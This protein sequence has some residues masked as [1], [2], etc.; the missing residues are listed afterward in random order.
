[1][2]V[3]NGQGE[4]V[5]FAAVPPRERPAQPAQPVTVRFF[6]IY[7]S[8]NQSLDALQLKVEKGTSAAVV[9]VAT[10]HRKSAGKR[11]LSA[12]LIDTGAMTKPYQTLE[13]DWRQK[14]SSFAINVRVDASGDLKTWSTINARAP[15]VRIDYNGERLEQRAIELAPRTSRYLRLSVEEARGRDADLDTQLELTSASL[16]GAQVAVNPARNWMEVNAQAGEQAGEYR[17]DLGGPYPVDRVRIGIIQDNT[18]ATMDVLVRATPAE[19]WRSI[20]HTVAY[21]LTRD[22]HQVMS[23][24]VSIGL[25]S[26]RYWLFR[27]DQRGGGLGSGQPVL[28]AGWMPQQIVFAAR[29]DGPFQIAYG[30]ARAQPAAYPIATLVPGWRDDSPTKLPQAQALPEHLLGGTTNLRRPYDRKVWALWGSLVLAVGVLAWM[31]WRLIKQMQ[32]AQS[33][34]NE[35]AASQ[36]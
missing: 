2:R 31:A 19:P 3:F 22:G 6:P 33:A 27:V 4:L 30:N 29:G 10:D 36:S 26:E 9:S 5:P 8:S 25:H 23:P 11:R 32:T 34:P 1:M 17:F 20:A 14:N 18:I 16:R 35:S 24:E 28:Y 12:Y 21:R 15:L 13:L 7:T